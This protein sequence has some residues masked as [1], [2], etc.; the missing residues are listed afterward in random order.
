MSPKALLV[1]LFVLGGLGC[2]STTALD[3]D[4]DYSGE[5]IEIGLHLGSPGW[6][7]DSLRVT[8]IWVKTP[9]EE[10]GI[11]ATVYQDTELR[12]RR[13]P[14]SVEDLV[15]GEIAKVWTIGPILFSCPGQGR[16][17]TVVIHPH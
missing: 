16:A 2:S 5:I 7:G 10:C 8:K 1:L 6:A 12:N 4:P 15:V 11:I 14:G 3:G 17:K 9:E 13:G